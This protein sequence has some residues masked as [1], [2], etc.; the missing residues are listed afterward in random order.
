MYF[1]D[2]LELDTFRRFLSEKCKNDIIDNF[3]D[4]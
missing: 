2:F 4:N 3:G 1:P